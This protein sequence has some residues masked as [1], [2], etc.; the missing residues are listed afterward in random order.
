[1]FELPLPWFPNFPTESENVRGTHLYGPPFVAVDS[2]CKTCACTVK[3]VWQDPFNRASTPKRKKSKTSTI[4]HQ[5]ASPWGIRKI[6]PYSQ[7]WQ[8][9]PFLKG[10]W[11]TGTQRG[12]KPRP[13]LELGRSQKSQ[14]E[15][16]GWRQGPFDKRILTERENTLTPHQRTIS[17][18]VSHDSPSLSLKVW[19]RVSIESDPKRTMS[20]PKS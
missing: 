13:W 8:G 3:S 5:G 16:S 2:C 20:Y 9:I 18:Q 12:R 1:M 15:V 19:L 7:L 14:E 17:L 6:D 11:T 10:P 4:F